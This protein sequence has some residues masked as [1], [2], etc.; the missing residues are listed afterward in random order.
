MNW[1]SV[2]V[3][4][5]LW[6]VLI[7]GLFLTLF[8]LLLN[9]SVATAQAQAIDREL[10]QRARFRNSRRPRGPEGPGN[11]FGRPPGPGGLPSL[12][13]WPLLGDWAAPSE[14]S[15][16][17]SRDRG[18]PA[19]GYGRDSGG[20]GP[21]ARGNFGPPN[22][23][24]DRVTPGW[25]PPVQGR[26]EPGPERE[27]PPDGRAEG[28]GDPAARTNTAEERQS[29]FRRSRV[30]NLNGENFFPWGE[31]S[32]PW[33]PAS[34][35]ASVTGKDVFSNIWVDGEELRIFSTPRKEG[36]RIVGVVQVPHP[37]TE[38]R[39]LFDSQVQML[40]MLIPVALLG[41][42]VAGMF[43][44]DRALRP[45]RQISQAAAQIGAEDLSR[46]LEVRGKDELAD[47]ASTFNGMIARLED[48]FR[49]LGG[50]YQRLEDA[51]EQQRRFTADAS[52]ELRTPLTRIKAG[53]SIALQGDRTPEEYRKVLRMADA[54]ADVMGVLIQDLL[55]LAR[56]DAGQ[57]QLDLQPLEIG[58]V[59]EK[60]MNLVPER[61]GV[62]VTI[63]VAASTPTV[64][65]DAAHLT[66]LYVN[67]L[68][69]ALRHT[70]AGGRVLLSAHPEEGAVVTRIVDTGE[71]IA[72]DHL[73]YVC[74]R[75]YRVDSARSRA[76][77]QKGGTGLGLSI[78]RSIAQAHGRSLQIE[79]ELGRGTAITLRLGGVAAPA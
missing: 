4:L 53:T 36:N 23:Y 74:E 59:F 26:G 75:F 57:F 31:N 69:N 39:R 24:R 55:L 10:V 27:R 21:P 45:V 14:R 66:R 43:L 16:Y 54:A 61:E 25:S 3:R 70:P 72:P 17:Y 67:L 20:S 64:L 58:Q 22:E 2:R 28:R 41:A 79:S 46:R 6:H 63:E 1:N 47:L 34:F 8:G 5:T 50:A 15:P 71:G 56:S 7:L 65:G 18:N 48:S 60:A 9:Y 13:G 33:D 49:R 38:H 42:G 52:H 40:L 19:G 78:C 32:E 35:R 68:D 30:L 11:G 76:G 73:P 62:Q 77:N 44:T 12:L 51:Y 37:M 29:A